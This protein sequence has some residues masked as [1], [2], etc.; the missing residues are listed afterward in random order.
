M[1]PLQPTDTPKPGP[2]FPEFKN[3]HDVLL[4]SQG[5]SH[6]RRHQRRP[7][8]FLFPFA[9]PP[10]S[11]LFLQVLLQ[12]TAP[13]L[14]IPASHSP[15][16]R[17]VKILTLM[18]NTGCRTALCPGPWLCPFGVIKKQATWAHAK[19]G[20]PLRP[21]RGHQRIVDPKQAI[22]AEPEPPANR[23]RTNEAQQQRENPNKSC[24]KWLS[25]GALSCT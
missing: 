19:P 12:L 13:S 16:L 20:C 18:I 25:L 10:T 11:C 5:A 6:P 7:L 23:E 15:G 9:A 2:H 22:N 21:P 8:A 4:D 17:V 24:P 3:S 1:S 14:R